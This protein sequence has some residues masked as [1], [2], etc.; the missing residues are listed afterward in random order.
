MPHAPAGAESR[1]G[2]RSNHSVGLEARLLV[3][4]REVLLVD[5]LARVDLSSDRRPAPRRPEAPDVASARNRP[6][7]PSDLNCLKK[8]YHG[9]PG[10]RSWPPPAY[11]VG[12]RLPWRKRRRPR[13]LSVSSWSSSKSRLATTTG[14]LP[15]CG[16][17]EPTRYSSK[18]RSRS[19]GIGSASSR[20]PPSTS[21]LQSTSGVWQRYLRARAGLRAHLIIPCSDQA[22][23]VPWPFGGTVGRPIASRWWP[24]HRLETPPARRASQRQAV[25]ALDD[26]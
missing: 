19:I 8:R 22:T 3:A 4:R 14:R 23:L 16:P 15:L 20:L 1:R 24:A 13:R 5:A 25:E 2:W 7:R 9:P 11:L 12:S 10:S 21:S 17:D 26:G 6:D 18:A